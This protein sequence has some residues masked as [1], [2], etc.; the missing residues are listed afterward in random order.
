[1]DQYRGPS[2]QD[3]AHIF[4][5]QV[6]AE[7]PF[8]RG[9]KFGNSMHPALDAIVGGWQYSGFIFLRSGTRFRVTGNTSLNNAQTN[10]PD[11]IADG[12]LPTDQR[13]L[14]HWY[15]TSAFVRH[16]DW[17]T[18]GNAGTNPL[19]ADGMAQLDSSIFKTFNLTERYGWFSAGICSTRS[20]T[21]IS[22][23]R[24]PEWEV[25]RTA[26]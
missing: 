7:V 14:D 2:D 10:R 15:D 1:M 17:A 11:R 12:N 25:A 21:L 5:S 16:T 9:R 26:G 22:I 3:I 4:N 23:L 20:I 6:S 19:I 18:Y 24:R 13:T 8:G